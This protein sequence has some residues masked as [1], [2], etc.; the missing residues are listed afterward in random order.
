V[1]QP[2]DVGNNVK[3]D[4]YYESYDASLNTKPLP[5]QGWILANEILLSSPIGLDMVEEVEYTTASSD[6][7]VQIDVRCDTGLE[8]LLVAD[9]VVLGSNQLDT[10]AVTAVV[11]NDNGSYTLTLEKL[12]VPEALAV[13][14]F[15]VIQV[16]KKTGS[17]VDYAS[18]EIT[19]IA[20]V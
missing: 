1:P 2:S 17:V 12:V 13:G 15:M 5:L 6:V 4:I 3:V 19:V 10:P 8:G 20:L 7:D 9:F 16:Q 11:D 14:D 18:N